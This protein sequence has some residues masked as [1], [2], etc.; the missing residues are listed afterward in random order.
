MYQNILSDELIATLDW[1]GLDRG[2]II[3]QQDNASPHT[4]AS[5]LQWFK[6]NGIKLMKWPAQSPDLNPI[7]HLWDLL[8]RNVRELPPASNLDEL[9]ER[10]QDAWNSITPDGCKSLVDSV[11]RRLQEVCQAKGG[12][13]K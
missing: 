10:A 3:F 2:E 9:W 1:Y 13:T 7:E 11:P 8:K 12:Y 5:T 6:D 4:A